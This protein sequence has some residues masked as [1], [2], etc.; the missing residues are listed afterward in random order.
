MKR[1]P[2]RC[3]P[4]ETKAAP[5]LCVPTVRMVRRKRS[6]RSAKEWLNGV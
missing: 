3:D 5:V 4:T 2:P 6:A 1:R